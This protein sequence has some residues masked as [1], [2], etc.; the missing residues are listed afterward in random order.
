MIV[1][2]FMA[3]FLWGSGMV[4]GAPKRARWIM[5]AVLLACVTVAQFVLPEGHVV[6]EATGSDPR[7]WPFLT[8]LG[9]IAYG[10]RIVLRKVK[11]RAMTPE[12]PAAQAGTFSEAELNR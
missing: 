4:M 1:V 8:A 5:I 10:Y 11:Q 2:L 9:A 12:E 6:R 3:A 7:L